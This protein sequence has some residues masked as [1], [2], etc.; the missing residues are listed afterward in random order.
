MPASDHEE[1]LRYNLPMKPGFADAYSR[2]QVIGVPIRERLD[3]DVMITGVVVDWIDE[4]DGGVTL[5][6]EQRDI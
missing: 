6:V 4:P 1:P 3:E 2:D 5:V